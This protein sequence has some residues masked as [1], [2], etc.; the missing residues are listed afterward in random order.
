MRDYYEIIGVSPRATAAEI[1]RCFR[2]LALAYHPDK[3]NSPEAEEKFK[4]LNLAYEVLGDPAKRAQYDLSL[5]N[6]LLYQQSTKQGTA[7]HRDPAYRRRRPSNTYREEKSSPKELMAEYLPYFRW[8]CWLG[9]GVCL[10]IAL[11]YLIPFTKRTEEIVKIERVFRTGR[12]G[13]RI[14]DHDVLR[15]REG[16]QITLF[17]ED[18]LYFEHQRYIE[19]T[20]T[21]MYSKIVSASTSSGDFRIRVAPIYGS[22]AFVPLVLFLASVLGVALRKQIEFS[23]NLSIVAIIFLMIVIYLLVK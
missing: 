20:T 8:A 23:F 3:N 15:T 14:Y 13:G 5:A 11:D 16:S 6:P 21:S 17:A 9:L 12:D 22:L 10:T 19:L 1:K 7:H 4:E 18:L 2:K